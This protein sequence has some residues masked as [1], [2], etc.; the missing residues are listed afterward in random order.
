MTEFS[1]GQGG[2]AV[3]QNQENS[4]YV[5]VDLVQSGFKRV[6]EE[7]LAQDVVGEVVTLEQ[8]GLSLGRA[9]LD[10]IFGERFV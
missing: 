2:V 9:V 8:C 3:F 4:V 1:F 5:V 7:E 6:K 10:R